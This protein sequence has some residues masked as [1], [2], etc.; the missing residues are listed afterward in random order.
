MDWLGPDSLSWRYAGDRRTLLL[1]PWVGLVQLS[2]PGLGAGVE[3][4]SAFYTEPWDRFLR[5]VPQIAGMIYDGPGVART[6]RRIRDLHVDIKGVDERGARYH[7]LDPEVFFW[8]H[9]T[10]SEVVVK[11]VD[12]FDHPITVEEKETLY[13]E[14]SLI[15]RHYGMSMRPLPPD[16]ASFDTYLSD[17]FAHSLRK[18]PA[19]TEFIRMSQRP[20]SMAQPWLPAPVWRV[21]APVVS[22]PMWLLGVGLLAPETRDTLELR[23]SAAD[24][25]KLRRLVSVLRAAWH[26]VPKRARYLAEA[27]AAFHRDGWP[28]TGVGV[29]A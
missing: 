8:A 19:V 7:A 4:H 26:A 9:A 6:G 13:R 29:A 16:R 24:E 12:V 23:W 28:E 15:W 2:L 18:T 1:G 10:I 21:M 27:R 20:A 25:K 5:S 3:Q 22:N 17:M 11:M 14:S